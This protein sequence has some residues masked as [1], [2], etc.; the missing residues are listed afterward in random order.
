MLPHSSQSQAMVMRLLLALLP[1]RCS[2]AKDMEE[3][4]SFTDGAALLPGPEDDGVSFDMV[5]WEVC[6]E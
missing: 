2:W 1:P 4:K 5:G 3:T 6:L